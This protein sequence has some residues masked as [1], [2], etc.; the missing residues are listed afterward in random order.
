MRKKF[1][2]VRVQ[3][4]ALWDES[5]NS[6]DESAGH[7]ENWGMGNLRQGCKGS[8]RFQGEADFDFYPVVHLGCL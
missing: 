1:I 3:K 2:K 4:K 8:G 6:R 5:A 7:G